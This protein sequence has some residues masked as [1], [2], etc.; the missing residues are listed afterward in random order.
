MPVNGTLD[1]AAPVD[2]RPGTC[3]HFGVIDRHTGHRR[4]CRGSVIAGT[5]YCRAHGAH[6]PRPFYPP[7]EERRQR[8]ERARFTYSALA[9][10]RGSAEEAAFCHRY[11]GS[12]VPFSGHH[13]PR[14]DDTAASLWVVIENRG[15]V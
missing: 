9:D 12:A 3:M 15:T 13:R 4:A 8:V 14:P 11:L 7:H 5:G 1:W 10:W 6:A 2:Q